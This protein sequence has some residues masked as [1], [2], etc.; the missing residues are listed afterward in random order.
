MRLSIRIR[1]ILAMN[2]LVVG[3]GVAVGWAGIEVAGRVVEHRLVD[4]AA[5]NAAG[6]FGTMR[7]PFSDV[8]MAR[9]R[10]ILGAEVA[11]GP[12]NQP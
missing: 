9:L 11:A 4:E 5:R 10:Q 7:L 2:L 12:V 6:I 8:M 3:V 1:L